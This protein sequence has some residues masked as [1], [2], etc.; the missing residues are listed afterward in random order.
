MEVERKSK[1]RGVVRKMALLLK[2]GATMLDKMCPSCNVPL[3]RLKSGEII[4][5][6][7]GQKFIFVE[8]DEEELEVWGNLEIQ[9]LEKTVLSRI[10]YLRH[11]LENSSSINEISSLGNAIY[12]LLK[13]IVLTRSIRKRS[14]EDRKKKG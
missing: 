7:C 6:K 13:I 11:M 1:D 3:F 8:T 12:Q 4:C 2:S 9:D 14:N 10:S 5:P